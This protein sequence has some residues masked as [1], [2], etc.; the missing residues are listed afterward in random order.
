MSTSDA[1]HGPLSPTPRTRGGYRRRRFVQ[2]LAVAFTTAALA[3]PVLTAPV[4][5]AGTTIVVTTTDQSVNTDAECSL[6]E[7]IYAANLDASK[8]PDIFNPGQLLTTGCAAGNGADIIELPAGG[9]FNFADPITDVDNYVGPSATPIITSRII[10]E[11][12]GAK[13]ERVSGGRP[14]RAF[15]VGATGDLDLREVHVKGFFIR[16]G[17]GGAG[18][19]GGGMGAGGAIYVQAGKLLVQW[20]TF[21]GNGVRGGDGGDENNDAGGGGGGLSGDGG[22]GYGSGGGGGGVR[23]D[24]G[25][26]RTSH[27]DFWGGGGGGRVTSG[28][29]ETPGQ[30]CGGAG[31]E[32][33]FAFGGDGDSASVSCPGGGGGGGSGTSDLDAGDGGSGSYGGGGGAGG[34][35]PIFSGDGG[36]GGFGAGGGGTQNGQGGD[37]GFGGGGGVGFQAFSVGRGQ[38]GTFGGDGGDGSGAGGGGAGLGG[39]IFGYL[40]DIDISNSTFVANQAERGQTGIHC[41][42]NGCGP[43]ANDG[44]GAGGA[45]FT[46]AGTLSVESSTIAGNTAITVTNGGGGG[47]VVYDPIGDDEATLVLHN[48]IVAGNGVSE[49]YTRNGVTTTGSAGNVITNS[50]DSATP[51]SDACVGVLTA[52]DPLLGGLDDNPPGRTPT[53][54]LGAGSPAI[55]AAVGTSPADDQRGILRPQ[56]D[57][58]DI[59]AYELSSNPPTTTITLA[60]TAPDGAEGWYVSA[61]GV[62][63]AAT[64]PDST[65]AH[66]RCALDPTSAHDAFA[67]LPDTECTLTSVSSDGEHTV[68]AAS[69]DSEGNVEATVVAA[70]FKLD[71]TDPE[72]SPSLSAPSPIT[73]GQT[74]VTAS[75]NASD[76]TSGVASFGCGTVDT[77]TPGVHTVTCTATD[78][79]GNTGSATLTYVVEYRILGFFSPVPS[80]KWKLGQSV[81]VKV[82]LANGAGVRISDSEAASLAQACR[83][84]FQASGAQSKGPD[85]MKYDAST[86]QFIYTWKLGKSGIGSATIV[87]RISYPGT[88]TTTQLQESISITR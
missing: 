82:A 74:G 62:T 39:A 47:I 5:R 68:Y 38:G 26:G 24:G 66:T 51:D 1:V 17:D 23:G 43:G 58:A 49:C 11:G 67:D 27:N 57:A 81:P 18:G 37:G 84:T 20:S 8:A 60:P 33:F 44:R 56:G 76:A 3:M 9:G 36:D 2:R 65:V 71:A 21:E 79:A 32:S 86:D 13:L 61:V 87:V 22:S 31:G 30:P 35:G 54:K 29:N 6:Q 55:D 83:V 15:V 77:S 42:L 78:H 50:V 53:M 63:I 73:V 52:D 48:S 41:G 59:G 46:V 19:G 16:G 72:L 45:I 34:D 40:A 14:T 70:S 25:N 12:R 64:D 88:T 7:A 10:I 85:C 4:A 75:A 28:S 69:V 80:S